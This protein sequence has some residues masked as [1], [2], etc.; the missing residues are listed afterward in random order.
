M[1]KAYIHEYT[2]DTIG[3]KTLE[4]NRLDIE[5]HL[6]IDI[7]PIIYSLVRVISH[8]LVPNNISSNT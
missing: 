7:R 6:L 8:D 5:P 4:N 1:H 2:K 3:R